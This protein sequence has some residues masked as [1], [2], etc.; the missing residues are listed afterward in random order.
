VSEALGFDLSGL[1]IG[2]RGLPRPTADRLL[3]RWAPF[4]DDDARAL[5]AVEVGPGE[6]AFL[7]G[8]AMPDDVICAYAPDGARFERPEGW[9]EVAAGGRARAGLHAGDEGRRAWGLANLLAAALAWAAA[10]R[11]AALLHAAAAVVNGHA[12]VLVGPSGAGKT[13]WARAAQAGGASVLSDDLILLDGASGTL[14]AL[15]SPLRSHEF[16]V[17]APG[18]WPVGAVLLP[19]HGPE[20]A[21]APVSRLAVLARLAANV[22]YLDP[23]IAPGSPRSRV[24][25]ALAAVPART[26]RYR[27]DP[28]FLPLLAPPRRS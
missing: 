8:R 15:A 2:L 12:F 14:E 24:V 3:E 16:G 19:E 27:P 4:R 13:T 11:P 20:P 23:A 1:G 18:R 21:L 7:P 9:I 26:L 22:L 10:P 17:V 6:A 25:D 5:L 28:S